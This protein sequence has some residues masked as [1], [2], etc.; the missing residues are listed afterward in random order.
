MHLGLEWLDPPT[1]RLALG[2]HALDPCLHRDDGEERGDPL[3]PIHIHVRKGPT[4]AKFWITPCVSLEYNHGFS[5]KGSY[6]NNFTEFALRFGADWVDLKEHNR[7]RRQA[8]VED[9]VSEDRPKMT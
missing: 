7:K 5:S 2:A 3:E 9:C 8:Y 6:K 4:R 1:P